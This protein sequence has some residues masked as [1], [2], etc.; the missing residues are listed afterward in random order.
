MVTAQTLA[1]VAAAYLANAQAR[2]DLQET[3][4]HSR[5]IS[6]QDCPSPACQTVPACSSA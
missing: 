6:M 1:D 3:T 4:A 5:E 2:A